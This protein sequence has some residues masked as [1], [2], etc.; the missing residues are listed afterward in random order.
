MISISLSTFRSTV[1]RDSFSFSEIS[2]SSSSTPKTTTSDIPT[3]DCTNK[4]CKSYN[5]FCINDDAL[6]QDPKNKNYDNANEIKDMNTEDKSLCHNAQ[7]NFC[8]PKIH[9]EYIESSESEHDDLNDIE[10]LNSITELITTGNRTSAASSESIKILK[11]YPSRDTIIDQIKNLNIDNTN[12]SDIELDPSDRE[13]DAYIRQ[14][15]YHR[16]RKIGSIKKPS[17]PK[18]EITIKDY[19][20]HVARQ[21]LLDTLRRKRASKQNKNE[22]TGSITKFASAS[23]PKSIGKNFRYLTSFSKSKSNSYLDITK[24]NLDNVSIQTE[25]SKESR[26][27]SSSLKDTNESSKSETSTALVLDTTNASV[28]L[29]NNAQR[30]SFK[31]LKDQSKTAISTIQKFIEVTF[32]RGKSE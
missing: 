15:S 3:A 9:I 25:G 6:E 2:L 22:K 18:Q 29:L 1:F 21:T 16:K 28:S 13:D 30:F 20:K 26:N 32:D 27:E 7:I 5:S 8:I 14:K 31:H 19:H 10:T 23:R 24:S 4:S 12:H 17:K 11:K